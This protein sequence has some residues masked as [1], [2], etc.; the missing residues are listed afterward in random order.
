M[1]IKNGRM[2]LAGGLNQLVIAP[3]FADAKHWSQVLKGEG[4]IRDFLDL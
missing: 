3:E 2:S 4:K 1:P